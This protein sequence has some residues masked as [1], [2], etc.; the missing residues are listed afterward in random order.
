M[1]SLS[2]RIW[3]FGVLFRNRVK[4]VGFLG[5]FESILARLG[6]L[7][8][9]P[10]RSETTVTLPFG[11]QMKV[12]PNFPSYR[13]FATGLY[14]T[15]LT[16][17][18]LGALKRGMSVADIGAN[19]GY[20]TLLASRLVGPS[21]RVYAFEPEAENYSYLARNVSAARVDNV[22]TIQKAALSKTGMRAFVHKGEGERSWLL[23]DPNIL[24][25][26]R[27]DT[28]SLDDF[29]AGE[30]WPSL[31]FIKMDI[32][33]SEAFALDG[34]RELCRRNPMMQLI[35]ELNLTAMRRI[36]TSPRTLDDLLQQLGFTK[37][38]IIERNLRPFSLTDGLPHT[39]AIYNL[40]LS[41]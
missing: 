41:K 20:Y 14:E 4:E 25:A 30:N 35:M 32:E 17:F 18:Y 15:N 36:G 29:F 6:P 37:G 28:I 40:L 33:G 31:D 5:P 9:P 26:I 21:G 19:V 11:I 38:Y 1:D 27:I 16:K 24:G 7:L 34:M 8:I 23:R 12:P 3:A 39:N 2:N 10:P 22:V 13:N